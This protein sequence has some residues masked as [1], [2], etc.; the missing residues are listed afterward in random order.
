V[1]QLASTGTID[2]PVW[3]VS[4]GNV[5]LL[6]AEAGWSVRCFLAGRGDL[7]DA[8]CGGGNLGARERMESF[9]IFSSTAAEKCVSEGAANGVSAEDVGYSPLVSCAPGIWW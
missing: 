4:A 1:L 8:A 3:Q 5:A 2:G 6:A 7:P 9:P